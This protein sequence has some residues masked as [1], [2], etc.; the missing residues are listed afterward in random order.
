MMKTENMNGNHAGMVSPCTANPGIEL[1]NVALEDFWMECRTVEEMGDVWLIHQ[2]GW[3]GMVAQVVEAD[4]REKFEELLGRAEENS[5]WAEYVTGYTDFFVMNAG[6]TEH[7]PIDQKNYKDMADMLHEI[8]R[9]AA[10][11]WWKLNHEK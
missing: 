7:V 5:R 8:L 9:N 2:K 10:C 3:P 4:S 1:R 11:W 6:C